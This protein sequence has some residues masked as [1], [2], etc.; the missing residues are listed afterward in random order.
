M[1]SAQTSRSFT[2]TGLTVLVVLGMAAAAIANQGWELQTCLAL[3]GLAGVAAIWVHPEYGILFFLTTFMVNYNA[4]I[5]TGGVLT[6]NNVMGLVF[7]VLLL[8]H[9]LQTRDLWFLRVPQIQLLIVI[10]LLFALATWLSRN[11][12]SFVPESLKRTQKELW[13]FLTQFAFLIFM[14]HFIRTPR[15]LHYV[16]GVLLIFIVITAPSALETSLSLKPGVDHRAAGSFGIRMASNPNHLAFYSLMGIV[17]LWYLYQQMQSG[18]VRLLMLG[19]ICV[20]VTL[21]FMSGSRTALLSLIV[22]AVI[23]AWDAGFNPRKLALT[24]V[25]GAIM[26]FAA[27]SFAPEQ[28]VNR[29]TTFQG[30]PRQSE[31]S[32]STRERIANLKA[33]MQVFLDSNPLVGTG[34]GNFRWIRFLEY[35]RK[36]QATHNS[37][38]WALVSGGMVALFC[39]LALFGIT[40]RDLFRLEKAPSPA[41]RRDLWM[42]KATRTILVLFLVFSCFAEAWLELTFFLIVGLAIVIKRLCTLKEQ[43]IQV[44]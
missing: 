1:I 15:H 35:D 22:L 21:V 2:L 18:M 32:G 38:L 14:I 20:L 6:P 30:D 42:I 40:L 24:L 37:Y 13:D 27:L 33:G 31:A 11:P 4:F 5:P 17:W 23:I 12:P 16:I 7:C 10:A 39:Y 19:L 9:F 36:R 44:T 29:M 28:S 34:L 25:L 26:A 41:M 3:L 43:P 8:N